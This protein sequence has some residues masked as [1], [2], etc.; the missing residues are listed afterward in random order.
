MGYKT[1]IGKATSW[2]SCIS[3]E[4]L[5]SVMTDSA[6]LKKT[7]KLVTWSHSSFNRR[8]VEIIEWSFDHIVHYEWQCVCDTDTPFRYFTDAMQGIIITPSHFWNWE[9]FA[10]QI[11][12]NLVIPHC[13]KEAICLSYARYGIHPHWWGG[14]QTNIRETPNWH[15]C[16]P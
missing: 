12:G 7:I 4:R 15:L 3:W 2:G 9:V 8:T 11:M 16:R 6:F 5:L 10:L 13:V 1:L 14:V